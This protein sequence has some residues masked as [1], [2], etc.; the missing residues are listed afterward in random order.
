LNTLI[1]QYPCD[2]VPLL[3][4]LNDSTGWGISG[5][6]WWS[7]LDSC[8]L[9]SVYWHHCYSCADIDSLFRMF[10]CNSPVPFW[11]WLNDTLNVSFPESRWNQIIT[12][13]DPDTT[14]RCDYLTT[15]IGEYPCD[16][17]SFIAWMNDTTNW[18]I[19][20]STWWS[21]IDS[22]ELD[23][24]WW[25]HCVSCDLLDSLQGQYPCNNG[26]TY[27]SWLNSTLQLSF[28]DDEWSNIFDIC[29]PDSTCR[30]V[31]LDSIISHYPCSTV[32]FIDYMNDSTNWSLSGNS[33]W[34][35]L[36]SCELDSVWWTNCV[37]C[38]ILNS[39]HGH[40]HC[41]P[42]ISYTAWLN[43]TL[44]LQYTDSEWTQIFIFCPPDS[45]CTP[46]CTWLTTIMSGYPC[47]AD[48]TTLSSGVCERAG[49]IWQQQGR[50]FA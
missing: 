36:N 4:Y 35:I 48:T 34:N 42:G 39:L 45:S 6:T 19:A 29:H 32:S 8:E 37:S 10:P 21:L 7:I 30:C 16:T 2:T 5:S 43:D 28:T 23:S 47:P 46:S 31:Y 1:S 26:Q 20:D 12:D 13:C 33:W 22:C 17:I 49:Y 11:A 41:S 15:L 14:C 50:Y 24:V 27:T 38:D 44:N 25:T 18:G 3:T 9:D 40:Y